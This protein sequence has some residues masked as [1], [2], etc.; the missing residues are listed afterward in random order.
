MASKES[1][2]TGVRLLA[3]LIYGYS[4]YY[5]QI[6]PNPFNVHRIGKLKFL[7]Y[8]DLLLQFSFFTLLLLSQSLL[9]IK[10]KSLTKA[11]DVI[12]YS[13]ALPVSL[14]V[15]VTFWGLYAIDREIIFPKAI[16]KYYPVW[17]NHA[18]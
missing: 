14:I 12:F 1:L 9:K 15:A 6:T 2:L 13:L 4:I 11:I 8:W 18:T 7:T 10:S 16:E 3:V 17:L 5:Q